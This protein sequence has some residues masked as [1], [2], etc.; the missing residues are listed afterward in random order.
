MSNFSPPSPATAP[1]TFDAVLTGFLIC[2]HWWSKPAACDTSAWHD[3]VRR[4]DLLIPP[5]TENE[6]FST[7]RMFAA[8]YPEAVKLAALIGSLHWRRLAAGTPDEQRRFT[9]EAGRRLGEPDYRPRVL[10]DALAHWIDADCWWP[11]SLPDRTYQHSRY[12][13]GGTPPKVP[14][15]SHTRHANALWWFTRKRI[16]GKAGGI[17]IG[18]RHLKAVLIRDWAPSRD[19]FVGHLQ[20][21]AR[22][23]QFKPPLYSNTVDTA[24]MID[25][26][27]N[28]EYVRPEPAPSEFLDTATT[29]A[30][31][32]DAGY[33][34]THDPRPLHLYRR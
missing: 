5:G 17:F 27:A 32:Q 24:R 7:S 19:F 22:T 23:S 31:W 8:T 13:G 21:T 4:L 1:I 11:P 9:V 10:G 29:P 15:A 25:L 6:T 2:G 16:A 12:F 20:D 34:R 30:P 3:W 14:A 28:T 18:H 26:A 33:R